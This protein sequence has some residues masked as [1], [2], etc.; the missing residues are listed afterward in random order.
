MLSRHPVVAYL[1]L[2]QTK[3]GDIR[4]TFER[5]IKLS[6]FRQQLPYDVEVDDQSALSCS[7]RSDITE[8]N[9]DSYPV[10]L[11]CAE[12]WQ[13]EANRDAKQRLK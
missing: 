6:G 8:A 7:C 12:R 11:A 10:C 13:T 2:I 1:G 9:P 5:L 3:A 4:P